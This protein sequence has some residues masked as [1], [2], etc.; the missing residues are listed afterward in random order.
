MS[1]PAGRF[2]RCA[3]PVRDRSLLA[4]AFAFLVLS[5]IALYRSCAP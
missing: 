2:D 3:I 4:L 1:I 5:V